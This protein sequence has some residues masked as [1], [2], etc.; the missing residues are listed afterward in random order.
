MSTADAARENSRQ[1]NGQFGVQRR[2]EPDP[3]NAGLGAPEAPLPTWGEAVAHA[4]TL[5][6]QGVDVRVDERLKLI[7]IRNRNGILQNPDDGT[8]AV[9]KFY[10]DGTPEWISHYTNGN[11]H[12]P[13]DGTPASR[14]FY[15]DGTPR[16]IAHRTDGKRHDATD[17][18]PA[19]QEF[20]PDGTPMWIIHCTNSMVIR[21]AVI[22]RVNTP[23][24]DH[25]SAAAA[26]SRSPTW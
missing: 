13:A 21:S 14:G 1:R 4:E 24:D 2:S 8:P 23:A 26:T 11:Y 3:A 16:W 15:P 20:Y 6:A 17:G 9:Q 18:T 25:A 5:R 10:R 22:N 7:D 19:V 12:D